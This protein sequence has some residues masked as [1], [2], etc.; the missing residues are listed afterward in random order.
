MICPSCNKEM[1]K[2]CILS[3]R[4]DIGLLWFPEGTKRP[5]FLDTDKLRKLR[6]LQLNWPRFG[7]GKCSVEAW[8]CRECGKGTF[9]FDTERSDELWV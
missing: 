9:S 3:G 6:G 1:E 7:F 2:G 8:V 5:F 4:R